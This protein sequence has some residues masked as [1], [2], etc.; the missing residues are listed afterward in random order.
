VHGEFPG[1]LLVH[2][3]TGT[4]L[5]LVS[6]LRRRVHPA[7]RRHDTERHVDNHSSRSSSCLLLCSS[8]LHSSLAPHSFIRCSLLV[9]FSHLLAAAADQPPQYPPLGGLAENVS[10]SL[11]LAMPLC[12]CWEQCETIL[13]PGP[14]ALVFC[15]GIA[16]CRFCRHGLISLTRHLVSC[17]KILKLMH[18]TSRRSR[19]GGHM[20]RRRMAYL[21]HCPRCRAVVPLFPACSCF[22][23]CAV[24]F[25]VEFLVISCTL[26][27]PTSGHNQ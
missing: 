3:W 27:S 4:T 15:P 24:L 21:A 25:C 9:C 11:K 1:R 17:T 13:C 23:A 5:D 26:L 2:T 22:A 14:L 12:L 20:R 10:L 8:S 16:Y 7:A 6:C 18:T 19:E